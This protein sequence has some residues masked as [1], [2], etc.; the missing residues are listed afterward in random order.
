MRRLFDKIFR[1]CG[2]KTIRLSGAILRDPTKAPADIGA[3]LDKLVPDVEAG[4]VSSDEFEKLQTEFYGHNPRLIFV[5]YVSLNKATKQLEF[6]NTET[7]EWGGLPLAGD[8]V[9]PIVE[10]EKALAAGDI[11]RA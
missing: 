1:R 11:V 4:N 2:N 3:F 5:G 7:G 8:I 9:I 10:F 6:I